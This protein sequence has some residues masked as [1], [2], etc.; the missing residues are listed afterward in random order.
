MLQILWKYVIFYAVYN[1][2]FY[3]VITICFLVSSTD[4]IDPYFNFIN[5]VP[6]FYVS[7]LA[8]IEL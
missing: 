3:K 4:F 6:F 8:Y 5:T 1:N 7:I 2:F